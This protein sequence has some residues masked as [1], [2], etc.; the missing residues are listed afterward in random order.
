MELGG[1]MG[2]ALCLV[3]IT[4]KITAGFIPISHP[5]QLLL[6]SMQISSTHFSIET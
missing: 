5:I 1:V 3:L 2:M 6:P 4:T